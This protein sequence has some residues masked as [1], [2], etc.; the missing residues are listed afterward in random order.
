MIGSGT[1]WLTDG[2]AG[3][4]DS[5]QVIYDWSQAH[6]FRM[7]KQGREARSFIT[8]VLFPQ[9]MVPYIKLALEEGKEKLMLTQN[10]FEATNAARMMVGANCHKSV[11]STQSE[12]DLIGM[13]TTER[14]VHDRF[15]D[16]VP[17]S[18]R[19]TLKNTGNPVHDRTP[20]RVRLT[21][22]VS[23]LSKER[24]DEKQCLT[25]KFL[26]AWS[27]A[28]LTDLK[29]FGGGSPTPQHSCSR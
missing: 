13:E 5:L 19:P 12:T 29:T 2:A 25:V 1:S 4:A 8:C 15:F 7:G 18:F 11:K 27:E 16:T 21:G 14:S 9:P 26:I 24:S 22:K 6:F 17:H 3:Y 20:V 28:V 23:W 10:S